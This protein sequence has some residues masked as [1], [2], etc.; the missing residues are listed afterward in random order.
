MADSV[1]TPHE[2]V[3]PPFKKPHGQQLA[4]RK[5]AFKPRLSNLRVCIKHSIGISKGQF[6]MLKSIRVVVSDA[7]SMKKL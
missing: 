6:Q 5:E 4:P 2:H 1:Y 7:A 3:L